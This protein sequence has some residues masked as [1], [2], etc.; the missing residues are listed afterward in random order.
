MPDIGKGAHSFSDLVGPIYTFRNIIFISAS[1][2]AGTAAHATLK[3]N[4]HG[5][6]RHLLTS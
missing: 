5:I 6:S 3:I 4:D 1:D 2:A